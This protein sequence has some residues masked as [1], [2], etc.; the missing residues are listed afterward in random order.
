MNNVMTCDRLLGKPDE[1][2]PRFVGI[3]ATQEKV[4]FR[5]IF[6]RR[7]WSERLNV[8]KRENDTSTGHRTENQRDL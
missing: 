1:T 7:V 6:T 5:K 3:R 2:Q 4:E 8:W